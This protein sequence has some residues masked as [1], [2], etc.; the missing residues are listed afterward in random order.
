MV[1]A[2]SNINE[3]K[4]AAASYI[5]SFYQQ[6]QILVDYY[7]SY[8]NIMTQIQ[9]LYN[10]LDLK[11]MDERHQQELTQTIQNLRFAVQK[12]YIQYDTIRQTLKKEENK[13]IQNLYNDI[14]NT[15]VFVRADVEKFVILINKFLMEDIIKQLLENSSEILEGIYNDDN[16]T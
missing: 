11:K 16:E 12:T 15:F 1:K 13:D 5:I 14:K 8:S 9:Y 10:G 4:T 3:Q 7:V 6:V 2:K